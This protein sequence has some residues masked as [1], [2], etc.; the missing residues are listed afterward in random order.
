MSLVLFCLTQEVIVSFR[1]TCIEL[2]AEIVCVAFKIVCLLCAALKHVHKYSNNRF[3]DMWIEISDSGFTPT[4]NV[5]L[6]VILNVCDM[7]SATFYMILR[8]CL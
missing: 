1:P 7:A 8:Y 6:H 4:K 2:S 5:I 3:N